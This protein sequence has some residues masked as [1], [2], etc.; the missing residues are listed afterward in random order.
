MTY[1]DQEE[2]LRQLANN[3]P[4]NAVSGLADPDV[5]FLVEQICGDFELTLGEVGEICELMRQV[6]A[7]EWPPEGFSDRLKSKLDEDNQP[8]T[9]DIVAALSEKI[10]AKLFPALGIK[11][12]LEMAVRPR[13]KE[14]AAAPQTPAPAAPARAASVG[15]GAGARAEGRPPA[16]IPDDLPG[17][18]TMA[19]WP[20]PSRRAP[21]T[22]PNPL[23][24][25]NALIKAARP[26][27][28]MRPVQLKKFPTTP[29]PRPAPQPQQPL[30]SISVH[31]TYDGPAV[32][33]YQNAPRTS[34]TP[35][36]SDPSDLSAKSY[37]PAE[38]TSAQAGQLKATP[39]PPIIETSH[40]GM[41]ANPIQSLM[42]MLEDR[43][44]PKELAR[45][46]E[47]LPPE[48]KQ[49]LQSVDSAKKVVDIGRKYALH[50]DQIGELGAETGMVILGF[51]HPD[52]FFRR[53]S[54]RID[55]PEGKIRSIAEEINSEIFLKIREALKEV[56][57]ENSA[58]PNGNAVEP[59]K[60]ATAPQTAQS[61]IPGMEARHISQAPPPR[62]VPPPPANLPTAGLETVA[63]KSAPQIN[64]ADRPTFRDEF[65]APKPQSL[66]ADADDGEG[67]DREALLRDI[68]D[69]SSTIKIIP[70]SVRTEPQV[71][72]P[73]KPAGPPPSPTQ[74]GEKPSSKPTD[75]LSGP[76]M[77]G[78]SENRYSVDPY[79]E[80]AE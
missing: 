38:A 40:A 30:R 32:V 56:H 62:P 1:T 79:R 50:V 53:A 57:G 10:F 5:E 43:V 64:T 15:G 41:S 63:N 26:E 31:Q 55:L 59:S 76:T 25:G 33:S 8:K 11:V 35:S 46:L 67:I 23:Y 13:P 52:Q 24:Q 9:A 22:T 51:T 14:T 18:N 21:A 20:A 27:P 75:A 73:P 60:P 28:V 70:P 17:A 68:E 37:L 69:S 6:I 19:E 65:I 34:V 71:P 36:A 44:T 49:A 74:S 29:L 54:R 77:H 48:L 80:P 4:P 2:T 58:P 39:R 42:Q 61:K 3:L 47:T 78:T 66:K 16:K 72:P 7:K 45:H 12:P